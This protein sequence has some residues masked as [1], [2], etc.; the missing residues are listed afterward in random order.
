MKNSIQTSWDS[1]L[2]RWGCRRGRRRRTSLC[3]S[4]AWCTNKRS[5]QRIWRRLSQ[6]KLFLSKSARLLSLLR[7]HQVQCVQDAS[8]V[9]PASSPL[10]CTCPADVY[11]LLKSSDFVSHDISK[12]TVFDGCPSS[13][14]LYE[15]EL[16]LRK[17]Y[18][19]DR[20]REFRCFVRQDLLL[21]ALF[22]SGM[23]L[24]SKRYPTGI[25]Q[26]DPNFYDYLGEESTREQIVTAVN[27]FWT[28][29]IK[30]VWGPSGDC[31][32]SNVS[33]VP[34]SETTWYSTD[35]F[36]I[37]LTR[38][39]ARAHIV[40]FNPYTSRTDPLLFDYEELFFLLT[41][42]RLTTPLLKVIDSR[43]HPAANR[44]APEYQHNMIPFEALNLS[45]GRDIEQFSDLWQQEVRESM[46][47]EQRWIEQMYCKSSLP[48][49]HSRRI[50]A[51]TF[52]ISNWRKTKSKH[53][54][55]FH[56]LLTA[57]LSTPWFHSL[58]KTPMLYTPSQRPS[59]KFASLSTPSNLNP[60]NGH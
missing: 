23:R 32:T 11:L 29:T 4:G 41:Q 40:D 26:R 28:S 50:Q 21:G 49:S 44:N 36:D 6:A 22:W 56:D 46:N 3:L 27:A 59:T 14:C 38:D 18:P 45:S 17:W 37:L 25:S 20:S 8:W 10:K 7:I 19:I 24:W 42:G 47:G 58:S 30:D 15:L 9:L 55:T 54:T 52:Q 33:S 53:C 51:S 57:L 2:W 34:D 48:R 60:L 1:S 39:L 35:T 13:E 12:D 43:A 31:K 16:V 5:N